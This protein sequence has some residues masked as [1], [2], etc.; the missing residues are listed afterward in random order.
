MNKTKLALAGSSVLMLLIAV[1]LANIPKRG[2]AITLL[3]QSTQVIQITTKQLPFDN[4][5]NAVPIEILKPFA[6]SKNKNEIEQFSCVIK[7]NTNKNITATILAITAVL[8]EGG[9]EEFDT[10]LLTT[11]SLM[12][13]DIKEERGLKETEPANSQLLQLPG[14]ISFNESAL[15]KSIIIEIRCALFADNTSLG[16]D[17]NGEYAAR[18]RLIR[19]G[20]SKYKQWLRTQ[21]NELKIPFSELLKKNSAR[22]LPEN[23]FS[24]KYLREGA[25]VYRR[26]LLKVHNTKGFEA[27]EAYLKKPAV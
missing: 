4:I 22:D 6:I 24:N 11:D 9:K 14:L 25:D 18:I 7:N 26:W 16:Y 15:V 13:A 27:A 3:K 23:E 1:A 21:S 12:H 10:Y 8:D 17:F 5:S 20:A 19:E 2:E